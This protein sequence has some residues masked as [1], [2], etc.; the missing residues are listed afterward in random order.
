MS[1]AVP[2]PTV[3]QSMTIMWGLRPVSMPAITAL[4]SSSADT[5]ITTASQLAA[6]SARSAK[7]W[8]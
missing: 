2:A 1:R 5:Q 3:E 7:A 4:T 8:Q 6:S